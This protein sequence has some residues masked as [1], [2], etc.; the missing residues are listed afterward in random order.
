VLELANHKKTAAVIAVLLCVPLVFVVLLSLQLAAGGISFDHVTEATLELQDGTRLTFTEE[1]DLALF[2]GMLERA[3]VME[4]PVRNVGSETPLLLTLGD[5][6]YELYPSLSLS[7]CMAF[8]KNGTCYL[9]TNEDA[10]ALVVRPELEYLYDDHRLPSLAVRS[11]AKV[12]DILPLDYVWSYKKP[13]GV[14]YND[15]STPVSQEILTCNLFA[16]FENLLEFSV[17]PSHYSFVVRRFEDGADGYEVPVTSLGG[18]HFTGDTLVSV[19]I[20][21]TW[22]QASNAAQYGEAS[23]RFLALYDVPAVVKLKGEENGGITLSAGSYLTLVAEFTNPQEALSVTFG[24]RTD[25]LKFYYDGRDGNS[26]AFLPVSAET[27]AGV[28]PLTVR[29]GET[30]Y[31]YA[32]TVEGRTNDDILSV[33]VN[34]RD[35]ETY[36]T[37]ALL[38]GLRNTLAELRAASDGTPHLRTDFLFTEAVQGEVAYD[39]GTTVIVGNANAENDA[40]VSSLKGQLY[41]VEQGDEVSAVQQGV[42]VFAGEL[43]AAGN[44]VVVDHGC[45]VFSYYC[46]LDTL[47]AQTGDEISRSEEL[48]TVGKS[49]ENGNFFFAVSVG[50]TFVAP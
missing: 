1:E 9:L 32:V 50:E 26:Y 42:C 28:Y 16:D 34:D 15:A 14:Y 36:F 10:A 47:T 30:E 6:V 48:G 38:D 20:T 44:V 43:G 13:D 19:E 7:G 8:D 4:E 23:Y 3:A 40:G 25:N 41:H 11:G 2:G 49:G 29:S 33:A 46:L 21:A 18:L 31:T 12:Y 17:E 35:Y 39:F 37:P 22:S 24:D 27:P 45:G 5:A